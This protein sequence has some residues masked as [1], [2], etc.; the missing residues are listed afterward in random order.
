M[1]KLKLNWLL[2]IFDTVQELVGVLGIRQRIHS[3][4]ST[5]Q[6]TPNEH[7]KIIFIVNYHLRCRKSL[8][9][10]MLL[11]LTKVLIHSIILIKYVQKAIN[12][13]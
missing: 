4:S 3:T 1:L 5:D 8:I 12:I 11:T 2:L 10:P 13:N 7:H 6:T 9:R